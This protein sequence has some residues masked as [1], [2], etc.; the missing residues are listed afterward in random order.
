MGG[1]AKRNTKVLK[2]RVFFPHT[3]TCSSER[4]EKSS[5]MTAVRER[6]AG[7]TSSQLD[8]PKQWTIPAT[9]GE[10]R[11][12]ASRPAVRGRLSTGETRQPQCAASHGQAPRGSDAPTTCGGKMHSRKLN[13]THKFP[14]RTEHNS[15]WW[16]RTR[17]IGKQGVDR[18]SHLR[19]RF[20][21]K[22]LATEASIPPGGAHPSRCSAP[23]VPH[24]YS[25]RARVCW[26]DAHMII[27][28]WKFL[29]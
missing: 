21:S 22:N 7:T 18:C 28:L 20:R 6:C 15:K 10:K 14:H 3:P 26:I 2:G 29:S 27:T 5:C 16:L 25:T 11:M 23:P 4:N 13:K 24:M 9:R 8:H 19:L 17:G 1:K 12:A